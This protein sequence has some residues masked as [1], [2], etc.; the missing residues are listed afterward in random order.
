MAGVVEL[1]SREIRWKLCALQLEC[2]R[3]GV[4]S[5]FRTVRP[6]Q[7]DTQDLA[8]LK[9]AFSLLA[10]LSHAGEEHHCC[11]GCSPGIRVA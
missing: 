1:H 2:F 7:Q 10:L 9:G 5:S 11:K 6:Q 4:C 3:C 8:P